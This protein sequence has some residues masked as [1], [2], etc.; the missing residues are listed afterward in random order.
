MNKPL[1]PR[2][3]KLLTV[4]AQNIARKKGSSQLLPEHVLLAMLSDVVYFIKK[5]F[6]DMFSKGE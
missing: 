3:Q 5:F 4:T 2:A 1:S 6:D